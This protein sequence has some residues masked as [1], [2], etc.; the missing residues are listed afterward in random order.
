[1]SHFTVAV[2]T[3]QEPTDE[4][5]T[6][7]M[8]PFH[9]FECTGEND[10][11]VQNV[12]Q[13]AELRESYE[14]DTRIC[15]KCPKTGAYLSPYDSSFERVPTESEQILVDEGKKKITGW[16]SAF[17]IESNGETL[18][19]LRT[20]A[21]DGIEWKIRD[22]GDWEQVEVPVKETESFLKYAQEY[23]NCP[24]VG[25]GYVEIERKNNGGK[26]H[27][28]HKWGW[29]EYSQEKDEVIDVIRRTNPNKTWD[30]WVVG[31]RWSEMLLTKSGEKV[32]HCRI[33]E[34]DFEGRIKEL[35]E[36]AHKHYDAFESVAGG[37]PREWQTWREV[38]EANKGA[39][40]E[41]LRKI[42]NSQPFIT[43]FN[44]NN[45]KLG[46]KTIFHP[47]GANVDEFR[48]TREEYV[49]KKSDS[50]PFQCHNML[51][52]SEANTEHLGWYGGEMGWFGMSN[53]KENWSQIYQDLLRSQP[54]DH[55][56]T[57]IDCHI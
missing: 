52:A 48:C 55:Y 31:G 21:K 12:S 42:Y 50:M 26:Y 49:E 47:F 8:Q 14:N 56:I 34:L 24:V 39:S 9:E 6:A 13:L 19:V 23:S 2:I 22:Y 44:E 27:E 10:E 41:E 5:L 37:E 3:A 18:R 25:P 15:M 57:V 38:C 40:R 36:A 51:I 17:D 45:E 16:E 32:N 20:N 1:M 11:Y 28:A 53:Q 29:I 46:G 54:K 43:E 33:D 35:Q 4:L 30:W 7:V